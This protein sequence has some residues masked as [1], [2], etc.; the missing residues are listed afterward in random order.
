M[1]LDYSAKALFTG[2]EWL[3]DVVIHIVNDMVVG[4]D[5]KGFDANHASPFIIPALIDLQL[6]GAGGKLLS[7]FTEK[8]TI[9][10]IYQ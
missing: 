6:Y 5:Q 4:I 8:E 7:E 2:S 3:N 9:E 10:K 1:T